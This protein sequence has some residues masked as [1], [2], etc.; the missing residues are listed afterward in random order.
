VGPVPVQLVVV[1]VRL[2]QTVITVMVVVVAVSLVYFHR[3]QYLK[4]Q[5]Y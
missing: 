4:Q 3:L 1:V 5:L 2:G